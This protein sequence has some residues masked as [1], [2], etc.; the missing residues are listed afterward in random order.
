MF[1][2][3]SIPP[4]ILGGGGLNEGH[5]HF[6]DQ[7][8]ASG[9]RYIDTGRVYGTSE[10]T[11]G[12]WLAAN[13]IDDVLI[14]TKG[15]HHDEDGDRVHA[16]AMKEDIEQSLEALGLSTLPYYI[17]HRDDPKRPAADI[18]HELQDYITNGSIGCLGASNWE[19][20]RIA[21]A[22]AAADA[23]GWEPFRLHSPQFSAVTPHT[24][25]WPGCLSMSGDAEA[26][27]GTA[28]MNACTSSPGNPVRV[29]SHDMKM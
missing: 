19:A 26:L 12:R 6:L 8:Y 17:L 18:L 24:M 4:L 27:H 7:W 9:G 5:L 10:Q 2:A 1:K 3:A 21:E 25:P 29:S 11:I 16:A 28:L 20:A 22:N 13:G 14:I 23:N 15:C